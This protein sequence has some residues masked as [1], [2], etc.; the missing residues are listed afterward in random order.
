MWWICST[1]VFS[2][3]ITRIFQELKNVTLLVVMWGL[4]ESKWYHSHTV[5]MNFYP[6]PIFGG[7]NQCR[8]VCQEF[9]LLYELL[10][11]LTYLL[12]SHNFTLTILLFFSTRDWFKKFCTF[13]YFWI[14]L[15]LD[16]NKRFQV[17]T[18]YYLHLLFI[19]DASVNFI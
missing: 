13:K 18:Y 15:F 10:L 5:K 17:I 6:N 14:M 8:Q 9:L 2:A 1:F 16:W 3:K 7:F 4:R 19:D 12:V 11:L